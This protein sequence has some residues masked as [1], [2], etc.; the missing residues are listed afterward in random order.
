MAKLIYPAGDR[1]G[2]QAQIAD[3]EVVIAVLLERYC[4][5]QT[6]ITAQE[7]ATVVNEFDLARDIVRFLRMAD[8]AVHAAVV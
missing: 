1:I 2:L 4:G 3:R 6:T 7:A 8:G 5:G